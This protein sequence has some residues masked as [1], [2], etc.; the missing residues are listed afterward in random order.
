[1]VVVNEEVYYV[2]LLESLEQIL[3]DSSVLE[4]V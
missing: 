2:P 3:N 4:E 1:M